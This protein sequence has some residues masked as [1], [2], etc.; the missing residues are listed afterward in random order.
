MT[1]KKPKVEDLLRILGTAEG[2]RPTRADGTRLSD[3]EALQVAAEVAEMVSKGRICW[4]RV[5]DDI[6][7]LPACASH[8]EPEVER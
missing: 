6:E 8:P 7:G 3:Q 2:H 1:K 4:C 5:R